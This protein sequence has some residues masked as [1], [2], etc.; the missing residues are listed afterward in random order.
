M[1]KVIINA[2]RMIETYWES[3]SINGMNSPDGYKLGDAGVLTARIYG[4]D[5]DL[6]KLLYVDELTCKCDNGIVFKGIIKE[7]S[8]PAEVS[9]AVD[10]T[11][12]L[13]HL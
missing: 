5:E 12:Q 9:G 2:T 8:A 4:E 11:M 6:V 7:F 3:L 1:M 10:I 13:Y